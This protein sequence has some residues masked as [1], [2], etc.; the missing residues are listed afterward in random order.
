MVR[1]SK[2]NNLC[3]PRKKYETAERQSTF[4]MIKE[5]V[6]LT[7]CTEQ[8]IGIEGCDTIPPE[9]E[10]QGKLI[11]INTFLSLASF[12]LF[13]H[14]S[15]ITLPHVLL[16]NWIC[17]SKK[18]NNLR[19]HGVLIFLFLKLKAWRWNNFLLRG[20]TAHIVDQP[21]CSPTSKRYFCVIHTIQYINF[22][23]QHHHSLHV[24]SMFGVERSYCQHNILSS[25][26]CQL[27]DATKRR[28]TVNI[29]FLPV[30]K[31]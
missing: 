1:Y 13:N 4:S 5:Q 15:K 10:H 20:H 26:C 16:F 17:A 24:Q 30:F 21:N 11:I 31:V 22:G 9:N 29:H 23:G 12:N 6:Q 7:F 28:L 3:L 19:H 25:A 8:I 18:H 2:K 27:D 14:L